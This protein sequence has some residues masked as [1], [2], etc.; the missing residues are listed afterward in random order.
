MVLDPVTEQACPKCGGKYGGKNGGKYGGKN[1]GKN[2]GKYGGKYGG[3]TDPLASE[4]TEA[5]ALPPAPED[6]A[7]T[8]KVTAVPAVKPVTVRGEEAPETL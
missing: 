4:G 6:V 7:V 8:V 5:T 2:G 1:G 3:V